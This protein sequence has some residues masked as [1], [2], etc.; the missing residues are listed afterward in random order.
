[1]WNNILKN[2]IKEE[3][4][5]LSEIQR[6]KRING[7]SKQGYLSMQL[8]A[9]YSKLNEL[10]TGKIDKNGHLVWSNHHSYKFQKYEYE[11]PKKIPFKTYALSF[12]DWRYQI[13]ETTFASK[14]Y[15]I[16]EIKNYQT[17]NYILQLGTKEELEERL[18]E[19][20]KGYQ[21]EIDDYD[22][23][24]KETRKYEEIRRDFYKQKNEAYELFEKEWR[25][26]GKPFDN[27]YERL[28]K[29]SAEAFKKMST[30]CEDSFKGI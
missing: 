28:R 21:K 10:R 12:C 18:K 2:Y 1:M 26:K 15:L 17:W 6:E 13:R 9:Y 16:F 3:I 4:K 14:D 29:I 25:E 27:E 20:E 22:A 24:I 30:A 11:I 23:K 5:K 8:T 19:I 7:Y